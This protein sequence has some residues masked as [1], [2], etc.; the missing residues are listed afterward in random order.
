MSFEGSHDELIILAGILVYPI[1]FLCSL[2]IN[3]EDYS[4]LWGD[5]VLSAATYIYQIM[6]YLIPVSKNIL[7]FFK[8][9]IK[10]E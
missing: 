1:V 8:K 10:V 2:E 5:F 4:I 6:F 3:W 9:K 7:T